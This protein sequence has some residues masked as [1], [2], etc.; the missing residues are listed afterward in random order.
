[1]PPLVSC[2]LLINRFFYLISM[3]LYLSLLSTW[4]MNQSSNLDYPQLMV[5]STAGV[6]WQKTSK[7]LV[8]SNCRSTY[9]PVRKVVSVYVV[10]T[11]CLKL[12]T[13]L[14]RRIQAVYNV[15]YQ[16]PPQF[17]RSEIYVVR[18]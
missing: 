1:M 11:L 2:C 18:I 12:H 8:S 15:D 3:I 13:H 6:E 5:A 16:M 4:G 14:W 10:L 17:L 9:T 7:V